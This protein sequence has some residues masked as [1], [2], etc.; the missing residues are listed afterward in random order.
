MVKPNIDTHGT[1]EASF[2][3][4][5]LCHRKYRKGGI[6]DFSRSFTKYVFFITSQ[7]LV[8][9]VIPGLPRKFGAGIEAQAYNRNKRF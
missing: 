3:S 8:S 7:K 6:G 9:Q 4:D 1:Y 5:Y 2:F